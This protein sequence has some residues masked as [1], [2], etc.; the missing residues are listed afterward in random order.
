MSTQP[1]PRP[2]SQHLAVPRLHRRRGRAGV[3]GTDLGFRPGIVVPGDATRARHPPQRDG[4][5]RRRPGHGRDRGQ[6][7]RR[8][9]GRCPARSGVYVVT[10]HPDEV[11]GARGSPGRPIRPAAEAPR[12][13]TTRGASAVR[14]PGGQRRGASAPT[15][16]VDSLWCGLISPGSLHLRREPCASPLLESRVK[17][18]VAAS[19]AQC[20]S[21][22]SEGSAAQLS[23][24]TSHLLRG[25]ALGA[26][27]PRGPADSRPASS[28]SSAL[29]RAGDRDLLRERACPATTPD[30][31]RGPSAGP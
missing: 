26:Q 6:G 28:P 29:H 22:S 20:E 23:A 10:A 12:T 18:K 16:A 17:R 5:A 4:L 24:Q 31:D 15:P 25:P 8:V 9:R 27:P 19:G 14:D 13:T 30:T 1:S 3:A 11:A 2:R 7:R 21:S